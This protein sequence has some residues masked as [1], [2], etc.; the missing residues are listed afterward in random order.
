MKEILYRRLYKIVSENDYVPDLIILDGGKTQLAVA[1]E[2]IDSLNLNI[3][4]CGLVK[5]DKHIT[6]ALLNS[7]K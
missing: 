7:K 3:P 5:N 1:K 4:Y 6:K 2:V